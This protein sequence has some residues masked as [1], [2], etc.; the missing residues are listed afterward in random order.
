[1]RENADIPEL[2]VE[3]FVG[4]SSQKRNVK[5]QKTQHAKW[6]WL[7]TDLGLHSLAKKAVF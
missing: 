7:T 1:L 4:S 5:Y 6:A 2:Q 3:S